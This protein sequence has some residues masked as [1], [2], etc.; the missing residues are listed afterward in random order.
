MTFPDDAPAPTPPSEDD[1]L[2]RSEASV[3]LA[4]LGVRLKP[5]TLARMFCVGRDGPACVHVRRKPY[6][7]RG[8]LAAWARRQRSR[9]RRS[10][11]EPWSTEGPST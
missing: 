7:P 10:A 2:T 4:G 3:F 8:E 6:Y 1:L 11:R 5:A 9:L